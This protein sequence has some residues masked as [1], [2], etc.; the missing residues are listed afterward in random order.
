MIVCSCNILSD[1]LIRTKIRDSSDDLRTPN[2]VYRC[3]GCVP[4]CGVCARTIRAIL[5]DMRGPEIRT[6]CPSMSECPIACS[7]GAVT[8]AGPADNGS[9]M[10]YAAMAP[11]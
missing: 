1:A 8:P 5:G 10:S 11:A 7:Q 6:A 2:H 3:L 9:D 4:Q